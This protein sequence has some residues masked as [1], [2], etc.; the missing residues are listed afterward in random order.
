VLRNE[1]FSVAV[2]L[3]QSYPRADYP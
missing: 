2:P 1:Y 3:D